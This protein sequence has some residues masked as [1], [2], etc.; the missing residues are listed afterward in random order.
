MDTRLA[1]TQ[2]RLRTWADIIQARNESGL[3]VREYCERNKISR[4]V[5]FYWLRKLRSAALE[6][7]GS[8]FVEMPA[9]SL[10]GSSDHPMGSVIVELGNARIHVTDPELRDTFT[11]IVEVLSHAQ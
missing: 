4:N 7:D 8:R 9:F 10:S 5:Y 2:F 6:A 11:M 1:T 3:S